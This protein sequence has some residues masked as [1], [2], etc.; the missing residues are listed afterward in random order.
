MEAEISKVQGQPQL[1]VELEASL[2][3]VKLCL[4]NKQVI[5]QDMVAQT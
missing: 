2:A 3:Y 1:R 4:E 5:R